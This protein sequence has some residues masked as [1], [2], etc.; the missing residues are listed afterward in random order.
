MVNFGK[1]LIQ[2]QHPPWKEYYL[3]YNNL[4]RVLKD[5]KKGEKVFELDAMEAHHEDDS[6]AV[7]EVL[8]DRQIERVVIFFL[9]QQGRIATNLAELRETKVGTQE[10]HAKYFEI[11]EEILL[12]VNFV[13]LNVTALQKI[14]K[15]HDK[16][17]HR[18]PIT[19][20]FLVQH[21]RSELDSHLQQLYHYE[22]IASLTE[23]LRLGLLEIEEDPITTNTNY[24]SFRKSSYSEEKKIEPILHRIH[25]ARRRLNQSSGYAQALAVQAMFFDRDSEDNES[26][27]SNTRP[28]KR[29]ELSGFLNL[30]S[31]FLF[32][33]NYFIVAPTSGSYA[34]RLGM[35]EALAGVIIGM[36][37]CAALIASV[38]YSW[39]SN[40][41]Y[42]DALLFSAGCA[43][44]GDVLY[45]LALPFNSVTLILVG[46]LLNGFGGARAINRRYIADAYARNERTAASAAFVTASALGMA[47]GPALAVAADI[48]TPTNPVEAKWWTVET[49]P[50]WIMLFL[51]SIYFLVCLFYFE[52]PERK[53]EGKKHEG[54]V[55][56]KTPLLNGDMPVTKPVTDAVPLW[57]N[58]P[59]MT[60][61]L[62]YFVLK[63]VLECLMS[64][65]ATITTFYFHWNVTRS[66]IFLAILGLIVFPANMAV[67]WLSRTYED[68]AI[69]MGTQGIILVGNIGIISYS[70]SYSV[71]QYIVFYVFIFLGANML[72]G[73]NMALLSKTLPRQW[74]RGT[75]NSG[76]L[77]TEAGTFG[78]V[79]GDFLI[80]AAGL[81][82][83]ERVL[84]LTFVPT[85]VFVSAMLLVC[86][87]LY[88]QLEE[89][90]ED[91]E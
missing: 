59:A 19:E 76:L 78:R 71:I 84:N 90:D 24:S 46:R 44:L 56:D 88:P 13:E 27:H 17:F 18:N 69:I 75:F 48:L 4:K 14:L 16:C 36:T 70:S 7:F 15:K 23:S 58:V 10:V 61:L 21:Y 5:I 54:T 64:S 26:A 50:G 22:G 66:G 42:K 9:Q 20:R 8:L 47:A 86:W 35:S 72:E 6:K 25:A 55:T 77:A 82:G 74:A 29:H 79:V 52:E 38:L 28:N 85:A 65:T 32:M 33:T 45:A 30:A 91:D 51:W 2:G 63:L 80:S 73:P 12:L 39:W 87:R 1:K 41:S 81:V 40:Y 34:A 11:G 49:A 67:A 37:P 53:E 60:T 43:I 68:R 3:D 83:L 31:T 62:I 89:I 57:K